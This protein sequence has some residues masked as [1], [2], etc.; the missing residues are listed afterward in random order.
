MQNFIRS[1]PPDKRPVIIYVVKDLAIMGGV[2]VRM[3]AYCRYLTSRGFRIIIVS[4]YNFFPELQ[5][6][7]NYYLDFSLANAAECLIELVQNYQAYC[8]EFHFKSS[9]I[10]KNLN[11]EQLKKQTIIGCVIHNNVDADYLSLYHFNYIIVVSQLLKNK[12]EK[13]LPY[14]IIIPNAVESA[15]YK[16]ILPQNEPLEAIIIS[17]ICREKCPT[18]KAFIEFCLKSNIVPRIGGPESKNRKIEKYLIKKYHL[19]NENFLGLYDTKDLSHNL[20]RYLFVAGVG[21]VVLNAGIYGYPVFLTSHL[22]LKYSVFLTSQNF[23]IFAPENFTIK[24]PNIYS[25]TDNL[26]SQALSDIIR[27]KNECYNLNPSISKSFM[28]DNIFEKYLGVIKNC[29]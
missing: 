23:S 17:R 20:G 6:Y 18:L 1:C 8:L 4:E 11:F 19:H 22:G 14:S 7:D 16:Y 28:I 15:S 5:S 9:D 13:Q 10:I 2:E 24:R 21:Q 27:G 25:A 29:G 3:A 26:R 12:Y